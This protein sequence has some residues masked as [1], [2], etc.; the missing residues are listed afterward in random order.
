MA[1]TDTT[2][3]TQTT[4]TATSSA[5]TVINKYGADEGR[6]STITGIDCS[7]D[8]SKLAKLYIVG[9]DIDGLISDLINVDASEKAMLQAVLGEMKTGYTNFSVTSV[10]D[11]REEKMQLVP[12]AGD[13]FITTFTGR[14]PHVMGISGYLIFDHDT[15]K[16][17]WFHAFINA[18][19]SLIRASRMAKHRCKLKIVFPDSYT[20]IGYM[21]G[22]NANQQAET[23]T[24]VQFSA[25]ILIIDKMFAHPIGQDYWKAAT[26]ETP[27]KKTEAQTAAET[28]QQLT[29]NS[30]PIPDTANAS[31][32]TAAVMSTDDYATWNSLNERI[33]N[34]EELSE[35]E[36]SQY[37]DLNAQQENQAAAYRAQNAA[38]ATSIQARVTAGTASQDDI[39]Q[40]RDIQERRYYELSQLGVLNQA[41]QTE[42]DNLSQTVAP[43]VMLRNLEERASTGQALTEWQ[44]TQ[45]R[46]LRAAAAGGNLNSA[47]TLQSAETYEPCGTPSTPAAQAT[48]L[49]NQLNHDRAYTT[50]TVEP[51]ARLSTQ[52]TINPVAE[53]ATPTNTWADTAVTGQSQSNQD[54]TVSAYIASH[55]DP[56]ITSEYSAKYLALQQ[57]KNATCPSA[58]RQKNTQV[59]AYITASYNT[60]TQLSADCI[61]LHSWNTGCTTEEAISLITS[62]TNNLAI[63]NGI[64]VPNIN[65]LYPRITMTSDGAPTSIEP[66]A[67][68][69][70]PL[71]TRHNAFVGELET[72][73]DT[74]ASAAA[75]SI[76]NLGPAYSSNVQV[77][78]GLQMIINQ[79]SHFR[80]VKASIQMNACIHQTIA[81]YDNE[82]QALAL[83]VS[84]YP[85]Y[86][87]YCCGSSAST[88][89][90]NV[91]SADGTPATT[92]GTIAPVSQTASQ[93]E[94][95]TSLVRNANTGNEDTAGYTTSLNGPSNREFNPAE[96]AANYP[97]IW[98]AQDQLYAALCNCG[99]S[100]AEL[101]YYNNTSA[102]YSQLKPQYFYGSSG[103]GDAAGAQQRMQSDVSTVINSINRIGD[104]SSLNTYWSL[105]SGR[106]YS[107]YTN[108]ANRVR[109]SIDNA[110]QY[111]VGP[112][113]V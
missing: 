57:L 51:D 106:R 70:S 41:Q 75:L 34:G 33:Q 14:R 104:N 32:Y 50:P 78:R 24:V 105:N 101:N 59:A 45:L 60:M 109:A 56:H 102:A 48:I 92:N 85:T 23:D 26:A 73:A 6:L 44:Q 52:Q 83:L 93:T 63:V 100:M 86:A 68:Y 64:T 43:S 103:Y 22:C 84:M 37:N 11:S 38:D 88:P 96:I 108:I 31:N 27:T 110:K 46:D 49:A 82:S 71:V 66:D 39:D 40:L 18:Y 20:I 53:P 5:S 8:D 42:F 76:A 15:T 98:R 80:S 97:A 9:D 30:T 4:A 69:N 13:N 62:I 7:T 67:A 58:D 28:Q 112:L 3:E 54:D 17:S 36:Y 111:L 91:S 74:I 12:L 47:Y 77:R 10:T 99:V 16:V 55:P 87:S 65:D 29:A 61:K 25:S 79:G 2:L 89:A 19:D 94:T 95:T 35:E 21:T 1:D 81:Q 90:T 107:T 72:A 113:Y